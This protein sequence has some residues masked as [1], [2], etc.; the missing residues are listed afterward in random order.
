MPPCGEGF[1]C[2]VHGLLCQSCLSDT[3][4]SF[5]LRR[6]A[7]RESSCLNK[8]LA[9]IQWIKLDSEVGLF[10]E[11]NDNHFKLLYVGNS[12]TECFNQEASRNIF[13]VAAVQE[14][15]Y[16]KFMAAFEYFI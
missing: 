11:M 15:S 14:T 3:D 13:F 2:P 9:H 16:M 7:E 10:V 12:V 1:A 4:A 5:Y 6:A 8:Y